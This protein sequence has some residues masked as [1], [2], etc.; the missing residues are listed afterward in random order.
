MVIML[1]VG[2]LLFRRRRETIENE[3]DKMV[4]LAETIKGQMSELDRQSSARYSSLKSEYVL[5]FKERYR[6]ISEL[7]EQYLAEKKYRHSSEERKVMYEKVEKLLNEIGGDWKSY[8]RVETVINRKMGNLMLRFRNDFPNLKD[9]DYQF[10]ICVI[11]GFDATTLSLL[12]RIP[13]LSAV[14]ARKSRLKKMVIMSDS[15]HK[16]D[17]LLLF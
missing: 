11:M 14:Y 10:V 12:F 16:D 13:S 17:Y 2:Y 4:A 3:R 6:D 15:K 8:E 7:V 5:L 9:N 1:V